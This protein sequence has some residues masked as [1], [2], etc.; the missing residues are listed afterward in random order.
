MRCGFIA[1]GIIGALLFPGCS[2]AARRKTPS[3]TIITPPEGL[4]LPAE[5]PL[6]LSL[7]VNAFLKPPQIDLSL[8]GKRVATM[9]APPYEYRAV[10]PS[11]DF[12]I[13]ACAIVA[14]KPAVC[15]S[16][17]IHVIVMYPE[18]TLDD[19]AALMLALPRAVVVISNPL[20]GAVFTAPA[21]IRVA[22]TASIPANH[23][24]AKESR[25]ESVTFA[26]N[27]RDIITL[28]HPPY[29]TELHIETPGDYTVSVLAT[30]NHQISTRA[31]TAI[32]VLPKSRTE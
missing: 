26:L 17:L 21:T 19:A 28:T 23:P 14:S 32:R 30:D 2:H 27:Y 13:E 3:V 6:I 22:A 9:A 29:T 15:E 12:K 4:V 24:G 1:A 16:R 8:D 10:V 25:V 20:S 18:G 31:I 11:R 7:S 5:S